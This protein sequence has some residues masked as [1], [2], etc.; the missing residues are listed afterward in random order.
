MQRGLK[1]HLGTILHWVYVSILLRAVWVNHAWSGVFTFYMAGACVQGILGV[2]LCISHY[3]KDFIEKEDAKDHAGWLR[4]QVY[5]S[6]DVSC[7]SMVV[8]LVSWWIE[9]SP[10]A[11]SDASAVTMP[12]SRSHNSA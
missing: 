6:K 2:Q 8:R 4:R 3:D 9:P 1:E 11:S 7:T 10:G 5:V 12:I